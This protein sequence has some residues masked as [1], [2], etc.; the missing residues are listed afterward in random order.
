[1]SYFHRNSLLNFNIINFFIIFLFSF[2]I[3]IYYAKFGVFPIDTFLHYDSGYRILKNEYPIKDYWIVSSFV[4][5]FIQATFFKIFGVNWYAYVMHSSLFN[6]LISICTY[7]FFLYLRISRLKSLI[8]TICFSI[9]AYTVSG[10]PFVDHHATFFSLIATYILIRNLSLNNKFLWF[11]IVFLFFLAFLSKQVPTAYIIIFQSVLVS[12]FLYKN[13]N[14][15]A[16]KF[17]F[18]SFFICSILLFLVFIYLKIDYKDFYL[19]YI[20]FPSSIGS[21]RVDTFDF[22][23]ESLFN[24]YKF[25]IIPL[26]LITYLKIQKIKKKRIGFYSSE[27]FNFLIILTFCIGCLIHQIITKNQIYIYFLISILIA[28]IE[29]EIDFSKARYKKIF[30]FLG[31]IFLIIITFKYHLRYNENR[32][33]HELFNVNLKDSIAAKEIDNS[34]NGLLWINPFF[35]GKP[36]EEILLINKG[37][38]KLD[39]T[40]DEIMLISHYSFLDSITKKSLN[41][42]NKSFTFDGASVPIIEGK[43]FDL[44]K[45]FLLNKI[46][47]KNIKKIFFFKHENISRNIFTT[48]LNQDCYHFTEDD[49]FYVYTVQCLK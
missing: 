6:A 25:L 14:F 42:P 36:N 22:S 16:I 45:N 18:L 12:L 38:K 4:V 13:K 3:N 23:I 46:K 49:I 48:Y 11:V 34:L 21:S 7:Y 31:I 9:L 37:K 39:E 15:E 32:K 19:Q 10:T 8:L 17:I 43:F 33:F 41:Y 30:S 28:F 2:L 27:I 26:L 44:Y 24:K 5:D 29:V 40:N 20:D 1:M 35:K 47:N